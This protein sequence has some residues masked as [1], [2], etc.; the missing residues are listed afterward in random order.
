MDNADFLENP[1]KSSDMTKID[2]L[3]KMLDRTTLTE[4]VLPLQN[5]KNFKLFARRD[6]LIHNEISG[7]KLRKLKHYLLF[8]IN[9]KIKTIVTFGGAYSNHLLATAS[10]CQL[11]GLECVGIIRGNE[12][13][14]DSNA[15]LARCSELGMELKFVSR[16]DYFTMKKENGIGEFEGEKVIFIPEGGANLFGVEGAKE[17]LQ[18][19]PA[20]DIYCVAQGTTT[21]SI[22]LLHAIPE[23][24]ELWVVP[25][26][27]GFDSVKEMTEIDPTVSNKLTQLRILDEF[28][29]GGYGKST[30]ELNEFI[31]NFNLNNEMRT[32]FVYTGK[33]LF[34][35]SKILSDN[36][37]N[38]KRILFVHTGG[39]WNH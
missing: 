2:A 22:G 10:A 28:H 16:T 30:H 4:C 21:T 9:Q 27:K 15:V 18:G 39:L 5:N 26:L 37:F 13:K 23:H 34:A 33:V 36:D 19:L 11:V 1:D 38:D 20:F 12:L 3:L 17:I 14:S 25:V 6:D 35:L 29:F 8:A 24:S 31:S 7:N 32:E